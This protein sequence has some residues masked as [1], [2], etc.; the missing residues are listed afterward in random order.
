MNAVPNKKTT[1]STPAEMVTGR[2]LEYKEEVR[3]Q[4]GRIAMFKELNQPSSSTDADPRLETGIN[5]V[6]IDSP[7]VS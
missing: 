6:G 4:F 1:P 3:V 5:W 7:E 2:K